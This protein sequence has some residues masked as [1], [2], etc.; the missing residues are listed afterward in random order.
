[1]GERGKGRIGDEEEI[2]LILCVLCAFFA[3]FAVNGF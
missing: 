1:M 3:T 2:Q